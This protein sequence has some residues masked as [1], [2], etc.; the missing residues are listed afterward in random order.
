MTVFPKRWNKMFIVEI[1]P[2]IPYPK[3]EERW[4]KYGE[5]LSRLFAPYFLGDKHFQWFRDDS[6]NF[7]AGVNVACFESSSKWKESQNEQKDIELFAS[8]FAPVNDFFVKLGS[9]AA[10]TGLFDI[11]V[12]SRELTVVA[13]RT[14]PP[15]TMRRLRGQLPVEFDEPDLR[16][17]AKSLKMHMIEHN[18]RYFI[19]Y[20]G[21]Q[22]GCKRFRE[23]SKEQAM[24]IAKADA[25]QFWQGINETSELS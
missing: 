12:S 1:G 5:P 4:R 11:E 25:N 16:G 17:T 23:L 22:T 10:I 13:L 19:V 9:W 3:E 2:D 15:D 7:L 18:E 8:L 14:K 21:K 6:G 20:I 24:E